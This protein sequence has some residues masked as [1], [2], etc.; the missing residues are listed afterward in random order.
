[1]E[2]L[3]RPVGGQGATQKPYRSAEADKRREEA[4]TTGTNA[5]PIGKIIS[6][7]VRFVNVPLD[8]GIYDSDPFTAYK[9]HNPNGANQLTIPGK[10]LEISKMKRRLL[11]VTFC[12]TVGILSIFMTNWIINW[13]EENRRA[14]KSKS[15]VLEAELR[16]LEEKID[17][18]YLQI[19]KL[20]EVAYA[21]SVAINEI[22]DG[23]MK[24]PGSDNTSSKRQKFGKQANTINYT[25]SNQR[26][27]RSN[28][29]R[30]SST[31][32]HRFEGDYE[33]HPILHEAEI[34]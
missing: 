23:V 5:V 18:M 8:K 1:M 10:V 29:P 9:E 6:K 31:S 27:D 16:G 28:I 33:L 24:I 21:N 34:S 25:P 7:T 22:T 19:N 32:S 17:A 14:D 15:A 26:F 2:S 13:A 20:K 11:T 4:A 12:L 3:D 30:S